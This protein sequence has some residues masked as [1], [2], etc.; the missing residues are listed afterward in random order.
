MRLD[1]GLGTEGTSRR[2][3]SSKLFLASPATI[4]SMAQG[5]AKVTSKY[6]P[7]EEA[8][9]IVTGL[10]Y[11]RRE[12]FQLSSTKLPIHAS[13]ANSR[14]VRRKTHPY[15]MRYLLNVGSTL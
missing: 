9:A 8:A 4:L 11:P 10:D 12:C 2:T 13:F 5:L 6:E 3:R 1:Y 14:D 15:R 7:F